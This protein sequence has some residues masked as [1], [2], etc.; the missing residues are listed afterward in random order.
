LPVFSDNNGADGAAVDDTDTDGVL[1]DEELGGAA[2]VT[3][4]PAV[5]NEN[6]ATAVPDCCS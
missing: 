3:V 6:F 5:D 1:E 2:S 4:D